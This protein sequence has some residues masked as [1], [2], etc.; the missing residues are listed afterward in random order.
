MEERR[1]EVFEQEETPVVPD[2]VIQVSMPPMNDEPQDDGEPVFDEKPKTVS[3]D[4]SEIYPFM[5]RR[6]VDVEVYPDEDP[7][8]KFTAEVYQLINEDGD[9]R[10]ELIRDVDVPKGASRDYLEAMLGSGKFLVVIKNVNGKYVASR[11]FDFGG[12]EK[13]PE[14]KEEIM[15]YPQQPPVNTSDDLIKREYEELKR[16]FETMLR[17]KEE[18]MRDKI[19]LEGENQRTKLELEMLKKSH[20]TEVQT[21]R[22]TI[23]SLENELERK[24]SETDELYSK[25]NKLEDEYRDKVRDIEKR[26]EEY[27]EKIT[28]LK[29]E[30]SEVK[31]ERR[32]IENDYNRVKEELSEKKAYIER[33]EAEMTTLRNLKELMPKSSGDKAIT[34]MLQ[35]LIAQLTQKN[36]AEVQASAEIRKAEL[37][38]EREIELARL[39]SM[40]QPPV[41]GV[42]EEEEEYKEYPEAEPDKG[43]FTDILKNVIPNFVQPVAE[44]LN[45][46]GYAVMKQ[47]EIE[48]LLKEREQ[49]A[50]IEERKK[51]EEALKKAKEKVTKSKTEEKAKTEEVKEDKKKKQS[52]KKETKEEETD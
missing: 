15:M 38:T 48:K 27:K 18:L 12:V 51:F 10:R 46:A 28:E 14:E 44:A 36:V 5:P 3:V 22:N 9:R 43:G 34:Q 41:E 16:K 19:E 7:S 13:E 31:Q 23:Q 25:M 1:D 24:K 11:T 8:S 35:T 30:L 32:I 4:I 40:Y 6:R 45:K 39:Q 21:L 50:K 47:E 52:K 29:E 2:K 42:G 26:L 49:L 17:D 20:E 33:L 37:E